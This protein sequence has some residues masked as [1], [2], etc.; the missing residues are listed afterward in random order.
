MR[1]KGHSDMELAR[2]KEVEEKRKNM[3][4]GRENGGIEK[5]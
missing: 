2:L 1:E 4:T 5:S 3:S